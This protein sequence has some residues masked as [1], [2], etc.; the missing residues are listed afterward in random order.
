M[1]DSSSGQVPANLP[2]QLCGGQ[3]PHP[4]FQ[5]PHAQAGLLDNLP[6]RL[7]EKLGRPLPKEAR[8]LVKTRS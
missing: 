7:R 3:G 4:P 6:L 8:L 1:W 5:C 2:R